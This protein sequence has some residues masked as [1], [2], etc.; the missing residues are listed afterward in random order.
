M[1][2]S[3]QLAEF[4]ANR[5][6]QQIPRNVIERTQELMLDWAG[7]CY[8]G[9][10]SQQA[11]VIQKF[12][13]GMGPQS[14][15][16]SMIGTEATSSPYFAA[17]VNAAASHVVEQDDLHNSSVF[18]PATVV[19]P[20]LVAMAE[21][22]GCSGEDLL[23]AAVVG[24]EAGIRIG[25]F[26]G[27]NHYRTFHT[28]ATA[29]TLAA[30]MAVANLLR[31]T[32]DQT[33]DALGSAGTQA[34]GLWE[35]LGDA[36]DSKQLHTA[37]AASDGMLA[38]VTAADGLS[39]AS[40]IL[41]GSQGLGVGLGASGTVDQIVSGLGDRWALLETSFKFHASCRHTHPAADGML[42]IMQQHHPAVEDIEKIKVRV[43]QAAKDVLGA[44]TRPASVHQSKFSMGFV[45]ALIAVHGRAG[46]AEFTDEALQQP[47]LIAIHDRVEMVVDE[48]INA[49]YPQTWCAEV[50]VSMKNG[51]KFSQFVDTPRGDPG[52][53]LT[54]GE[55]EDKAHRL[56]AHYKVIAPHALDTLIQKI[57]KLPARKNIKGLFDSNSA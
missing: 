43:Y 30:A 47:Q 42:Q 39:G 11:K 16:S 49:R 31:L 52:N 17:M 10:H 6:F 8:A 33:L 46:V 9:S 24:Y 54:P 41:E 12:A 19:F 32:A 7:S 34:A 53:G 3:R 29:G 37:K 45:L 28:T 44:V 5:R 25:E 55:L 4:C 35:F 14:G 38:A 40:K 21:R 36:A 2:E 26:L 1:S 51:G 56:V 20:P 50:I 22:D 18:H 57:W 48:E 13:A 23:C 27:Q 15:P